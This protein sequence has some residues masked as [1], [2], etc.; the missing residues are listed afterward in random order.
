MCD[1]SEWG[2]LIVNAESFSDVAIGFGEVMK[3]TKNVKRAWLAKLVLGFALLSG[4]GQAWG[5]C[6]GTA[7]VAVPSD[8][9][10]LFVYYG[11]T[12][13][14]INLASCKQSNGFCKIELAKLS[15]NND[16]SFVVY[17]TNAQFSNIDYPGLWGIN[18]TV[19][20]ANFSGRPSAT[21]LI[22]P[23][24]G[25]VVYISED[26]AAPGTTYQSA[27]PPNAKYFYFVPPD[28]PS[29]NSSVPMLSVD[30][31]VT[32]VAMKTDA[33]RCGWFYYVWFNE[34]IP[35]SIVVFRDSDTDREE[36]IGWDGY[37][38]AGVNP[39]GIPMNDV[40]TSFDAS[41]LY[42]VPDASMWPET[43]T[44]A[45]KGF[46]IADPMVS[47]S[48]EYKLAAIIYDSDASLHPAFSCYATGGE[49]CQYGAQ[50]V[51]APQ[52][53]AAVQA[54]VGVTTGIVQDTLG[55]DKKPL[56]KTA[57]MGGN[58]EK[59]FINQALFDQ[60]FRPTV[61]V[62]EMSC[63]DLTFSRNASGKWEFDSD[64]YTSPGITVKGGFYPVEATTDANIL[65]EYGSTPVPAARKKRMAEGP[66]FYGPKLRE[67]DAVEG[68]PAIDLFCNGG[69]WTGG[70]DCETLFADG[71]GTDAVFKTVYGASACG[72]GWS[73]PD[74]A[75]TG[76]PL[77]VSGTEKVATTGGDSRWTSKENATGTG[78]RNQQ[79]C[80]ES[81][82]QFVYKPG[83]RFNFRG[84]DDIWVFIGGKLAVDLGG[85]HLAAPA[86]AVLDKLTDKNGNPF[87]EGETYDLDIFFCDRRTTMSNVRI[88]TN[89][90]IQQSN[91]IEYPKDTTYVGEGTAFQICYTETGS[92]D[93]AAALSGASA[94]E[95]Q[96][97][98]SEAEMT[99]AGVALHYA[100]YKGNSPYTT[101]SGEVYD[102][103]WF[104]AQ[105]AAGKTT[106]FGALD[107]SNWYR[108]V[109]NKALVSGL[110]SGSYR[111]VAS[112]NGKT[113]V[114]STVRVAGSLDVLTANG[115]DTTGH[116]YKVVTTAMAGVRVPVYVGA[117]GEALDDGNLDV[118]L[119]SAV[120]EAYT[121]NFSDGLLVFADSNGTT[122]LTNVDRL[123]VGARGVDTVWATIPLSAMNAT[124]MTATI[125]VRKA[126]LTLT[127]TL[128]A[129]A[130]VDST[131]STQ[132]KGYGNWDISSDSILYRGSDYTAYVMMFDPTTGA[133]CSSCNYGLEVNPLAT[134]NGV[135]GVSSLG[136]VEGK[137]FVNFRSSILYPTATGDSA[138]FTV[139]ATENA[140]ISA[141]W[142]GLTFE[143]PPV[144]IP[145]SVLVFDGRGG[146]RT[147]TGLD[148]AYTNAEYLDGIADSLWIRYHRPFPKDS[149]PDS[150]VVQWA[151]DSADY[152]TIP[153][154][155]I[156][157][158]AKALNDEQYDSV[159]AFGGLELSKEVQTATSGKKLVSHAT[160][161][162]NGTVAHGQFSKELTD[163]V[164]PIIVKAHIGELSSGL[165]QVRVTLSEKIQADQASVN[166]LFSYYLRSATELNNKYQTVA[167]TRATCGDSSV[168]MIYNSSSGVIP[169]SGDFVRAVPGL[170]TD[171]NG[172][173]LTDYMGVTVPSPWMMLE[174]DAAST[175][176]SI[177]MGT[178]SDTADSPNIVPHVIGIY[179]SIGVVSE[180]YPNTIGY[181]IK[182]DMGNIM[183]DPKLDS[184]LATGKISLDDVKLHY[185]LDI[186]TNLGTFVARKSGNIACSDS[187]FGGNCIE[188]RGYVYVSWNG[189]TDKGRKV[190]VGAYIA[191]LSTYAKVPT[192][193]KLGKHNVTETWGFRRVK[194]K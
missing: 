178:V 138:F 114:I 43:M 108:P 137:G 38:G 16:S 69:G 28:D 97:Y 192:K 70:V 130:F 141:K 32:G 139:S 91:G 146:P 111:I 63:F 11:N 176:A 162:K 175:I 182:T 101:A 110:P 13:N 113:Q 116:V 22:C 34:E 2:R 86:Y 19:Y 35:N 48:C 165:F 53:Q 21:D 51:S 12:E 37:D 102:E 103:A 54:C 92:G 84:D 93:C 106:F 8:W 55:V 58:G 186:F 144:P 163:N 40:F 73:C 29:W 71:D 185:E 150:I 184:L 167:S 39:A 62:N 104:D 96:R 9:A 189:V 66:V 83:L 153:K 122:P 47:G 46:S 133:I 36:L 191:K 23:G 188:N 52:A 115:K 180:M 149:L 132:L 136:I 112:I 56:L 117:I 44:D 126:T 72:F 3:K 193:G 155:E 49:G 125:S 143:E 41:T 129:I 87:V 45:D 60:L 1:D 78:G 75:P 154:E 80:F 158:A 151:L 42:F 57:A 89:M 179:D 100:L 82:A 7:Y 88:N 187:L 170:L 30:G 166:S 25:N 10:D 190:G 173:G 81:H 76:W 183:T 67:V 128:P 90:Y 123:E 6:A 99:A 168:T 20:N 50:G 61:N 172:N 65:T 64:N 27:E 18:G 31:G 94:T 109:V 171:L 59:C 68:V 159:L 17:T 98:C 77:F 85:T 152:V 4:A 124:S 134:A 5:A 181:L 142:S 79:F 174:G 148:P 33:T 177:K 194:A 157:K 147:Y 127:F 15:G 161:K 95:K 119:E 107:L 145:D 135:T 118:D 14:E 156:L 74:Q 26:A 164:S 24:D 105:H 140:L 131:Y 160:Y 120:G 121:V 169:Q